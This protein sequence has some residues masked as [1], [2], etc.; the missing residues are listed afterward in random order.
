MTDERDPFD[1]ETDSAAAAFEELRAEISVMR[2]AVEAIPA[3]LR[4]NRP[5]DYAPTLGAIVKAVQGVEKR[6]ADIEGHPAIKLRPEEY[7]GTIGPPGTPCGSPW[8]C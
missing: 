6:L 2:R 3:S 1:D 7:G 5:L 8:R 4:K